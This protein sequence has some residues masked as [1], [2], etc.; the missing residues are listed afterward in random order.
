MAEL[1]DLGT[2]S[3]V[4]AIAG[5]ML[6][7]DHVTAF[8]FDGKAVEVAELNLKRNRKESNS[9]KKMS[10]DGRVPGNSISSWQT[11]FLGPD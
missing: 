5:K 11:L 9:S 8:D 2:G 10:S 4:L 3:G 1:P 7:A 6:G